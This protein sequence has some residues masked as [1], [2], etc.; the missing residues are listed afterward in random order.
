MSSSTS[1]HPPPEH[2][3][4]YHERQEAL[5]CGQHALNN[6]LQAPLLS[7]GH[8]AEIA[9]QLDD[10]E[11]KYMAQNNEGGVHS[12]DYIRR[13]QE[14]SNNVDA[15]GN[16]SIQVLK[17]ALAQFLETTTTSTNVDSL[18]HYQP[19]LLKDHGL[20][21]VT[22]IQGFLCHKS[23][24]W[25][26][27]R[28]I[29]GRFFNLN[30]TL[31]QP[32]PVSHFHLGTEMENFKAQ[33]YTVFCVIEGLPPIAHVGQYAPNDAGVNVGRWHCMKDLLAAGTSKTIN[34][35]VMMQQGDGSQRQFSSSQPHNASSKKPKVDPWQSLQGAGLRL[36]GKSTSS[37]GATTTTGG[38]STDLAEGL[39]EEEQLQ[40]ALQLSQAAHDD[41]NNNNNSQDA[42]MVDL[43]D[44]G[45]SSVPVPPEPPASSS[46]AGRLQFKWPNQRRV[47]RFDL[48]Q[49]T[50]GALYSYAQQ[51]SPSDGPVELRAGFP[52]RSLQAQKA[53]TLHA[54]GIRSGESIQV[55]IL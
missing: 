42:N 45:V 46:S 15:A 2:V 43:A 41:N 5:L 11:L 19:S 13:L 23:D 17:Q 51:E 24:H 28:Q 44:D 18:P 8:L 47:R 50:V 38:I 30:S 31:E 55:T 27:I 36:D 20:S 29:A 22:Q 1:G 10:L 3:W 53:A 6:L 21:D 48:Q 34:S 14:G 40:L 33:G 54:A 7:A 12:K 25:F 32:E 35:R 9:H 39:T 52:P 16:F 26:A 49:D 37:A 4:I